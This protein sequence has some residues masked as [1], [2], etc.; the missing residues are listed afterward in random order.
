MH[1]PAIYY[2]FC[3]FFNPDSHEYYFDWDK[4]EIRRPRTYFY[5][6][7]RKDSDDSII[8]VA[9]LYVNPFD[10]EGNPGPGGQ[11]VHDVHDF[12]IYV[13]EATPIADPN[14]KDSAVEVNG[15]IN[16]N[17]IMCNNTDLH[18]AIDSLSGSGS[19]VYIAVT[20]NDRL[21][22]SSNFVKYVAGE[23]SST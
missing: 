9:D 7:G 18:N 23:I 5:A 11:A 3:V 10:S 16:T 8:L 6:A 21:L 13:T 17:V 2:Y 14:W 19:W 22:E 1:I 15:T 12:K 4:A 20:E